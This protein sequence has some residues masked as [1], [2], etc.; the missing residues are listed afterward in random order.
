MSDAG[1]IV[2]VWWARSPRSHWMIGFPGGRTE[3]AEKVY[4]RGG[5]SQLKDDG[6]ME[7]ENG[8]RGIMRVELESWEPFVE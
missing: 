6:F 8:P 2:A 1:Q 5:F 4:F 3:R 7:L